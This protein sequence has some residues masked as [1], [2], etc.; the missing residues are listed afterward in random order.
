MENLFD[1]TVNEKGEKVLV[2]TS[3]DE[4][5]V[6]I[7]S[8]I[9]H[10]GERVFEGKHRIEKIILP[11]GLRTIGKKAFSGCYYAYMVLPQG[12]KTIGENA[13]MFCYSLDLPLTQ[14]LT[15]IGKGAFCCC[16]F[17]DVVLP[18]GLEEIDDAVFSECS[19]LKSIEIPYSVKQI[20]KMAFSNCYSLKS[21]EIPNSVKQI[22]E[23]A[24]S[25]SYNFKRIFIPKSVESIGK[26]AFEGC[27]NLNIYCEGDTK[28]GWID[29]PERVIT[30]DNYD[31]DS[32]YSF[33][34]HR[35]AGSFDYSKRTEVIR[36]SFNPDKR[37][38]YTNV[39][40]EEFLK[41]SESE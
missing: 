2:A 32:L 39:S 18:Q 20:G 29:M 15:T 19:K 35:S 3:I 1:I 24:F 34:F 10:I 14:G 36:N 16:T 6:T 12:V 38:V 40:R 23:R 8:D 11:Q 22:G 7:P 37:P 9:V 31:E 27:R 25:G 5:T 33:N 26:D 17:S 13:F 30:H 41:L 4:G 21:V 28:D